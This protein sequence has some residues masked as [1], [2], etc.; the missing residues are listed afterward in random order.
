MTAPQTA[1]GFAD[2]RGAATN[3]TASLGRNDSGFITNG[4]GGAVAVLDRVRLYEKMEHI[5]A[6]LWVGVLFLYLQWLWCDG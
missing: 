5:E 2:A 6:D 1:R 3:R 4:E